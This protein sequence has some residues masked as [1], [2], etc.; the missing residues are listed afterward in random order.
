MADGVER[1]LVVRSNLSLEGEGCEATGLPEKAR[2]ASSSCLRAM[3][4]EDDPITLHFLSEVLEGEGFVVDPASSL[5]EARERLQSHVPD[6]LLL[7]LA[8]PDGNGLDILNTLENRFSTRVILVTADESQEVSLAA[9]KLGASSYFVK[10]LDILRFKEALS[11]ARR[12]HE[13]KKEVLALRNELRSL[14]R[15]GPLLGNSRAMRELYGHILKVAPIDATVLVTGESGSG[16]ELVARTLHEFSLRRKAPF[17]PVNCGAISAQLIESELFGHEK[18]SFTGAQSMHQGHFERA[19][20]GTLFLDEI[21]E[22]PLDLQVKLLRVLETGAFIRVGGIQEIEVDVRVVAATNR[23][24]EEAVADGKMR[25]DLRYRLNVFPV[26]VP[27]LREREADLELLAAHFLAQFN[28]L[29]GTS[30]SFSKETLD[31]LKGYSWPGNVRE[32]KNTIQR[33]FIVADGS[34]TPDCLPQ[35][36]LCNT[37]GKLKAEPCS[38]GILVGLPLAEA[39]RRLILATLD[40]H[41]GD[42]KKTAGALGISLRTLYNRLDDYRSA[43]G[44]A[45]SLPSADPFLPTISARTRSS[46]G[47]STGFGTWARKPESKT[48]RRSSPLA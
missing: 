5:K 22:M 27:P 43:R 25:E 29:Q 47:S 31:C 32:L 21:S 39:E 38:L 12:A 24:L 20:G 17:L 42:K 35:E 19:N 28:E 1:I 26:R 36:I 3:V 4:V 8:L 30:I 23:F 16:K 2:E 41:G 11:N 6:V 45:V 9:L 48:R 15:F 14:G 18:G 37:H 40:A 34:I 33:A 46:S 7:D 44:E 13:L 10:P